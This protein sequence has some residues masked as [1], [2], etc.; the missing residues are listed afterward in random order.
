MKFSVL[1]LLDLPPLEREVFLYIS[2][3]GPVDVNTLAGGIGQPLDSIQEALAGLIQQGRLQQVEGERYD[4]LLGR[5]T[6]KTTLPAQLWP[7]LLATGR[8]YTEKEIATLRTAIPM[9]QFAR[10]KLSQFSDHGPNHALRIKSFATQLGYVMGLTPVERFLLRTAA[11]F[12]DIGNVIER[13]RHHTISQETVLNLAESGELPFDCKEAQLIG[14]LCRWHRREYDPDQVDR[15]QSEKIRTGLLASILR[16][17]D[18]MDI[19]H[20][21]SDYDEKFRKVLQFFFPNEMPYWTSLE[22]I[23][24]VRIRCTPEITLQV[25]TKDKVNGNMQIEMLQ[26]DLASTPLD[27]SVQTIEVVGSRASPASQV[28]ENALLVFPFEAN[29]LVMAAL[30]REHL[31]AAG[32]N[33]DLL[34]YPDTPDGPVWLWREA[35]PEIKAENFN[36]LVVIGDRASETI[37]P[38]LGD[39]LQRWQSAGVQVSILNRHEANW[40]RLPQLLE[41]GVDVV[42]GGDWAYFWGDTVR[43]EDLIWGR[44]AALCS[45]DPTQANVRL[46][47]PEQAI[48]FG[49]LKLVYDGLADTSARDTAGWV[50]LAGPILDRIAANDQTYFAEQATAFAEKYGTPTTPYRVKNRVIRFDQA[51]GPVPQACYWVLEAAIEKQ[52]LKQENDIRFN[53]PYAIATWPEADGSSDNGSSADAV[54]VLAISHWREEEAI[55]IRF[56]YPEDVGPPPQGHESMI[57]VRLPRSQ[58]TAVIEKLLVACNQ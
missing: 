35:L 57:H 40:S 8:L 24:G 9:L 29:S 4:V 7:A 47:A 30:S 27:W 56:L 10:A 12:H 31:R 32:Y 50:D 17:A 5:I 16:V 21:R 44:I 49:L 54:E 36:R 18:A 43:P 42:L 26:G 51:P 15:L 23:L 14:L 2:R 22:D 34:C 48:T 1:D 58:A 55:P 45:R 41:M 38:L 37:T 11:L 39:I 53:V 25:F 28:T 19:D 46:L 20:R 52:G 13:E 6:P 33:I 3:N